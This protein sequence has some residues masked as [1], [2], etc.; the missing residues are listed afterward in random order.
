MQQL[1]VEHDGILYGHTT[2]QRLYKSLNYHRSLSGRPKTLWSPD[3]QRLAEAQFFD[4]SDTAQWCSQSGDFWWVANDAGLS[5]GQGGERLAFFP[6]CQNQQGP[7]HGYP[8]SP[9]SDTNYEV[10]GEIIK[11]W[12]DR[13]TI[14]RIW[15]RRMRR[16]RI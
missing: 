14:N 3:V 13:G 11:E 1:K 9:N 2:N 16:G 8:V 4:I 15:A 6:R 7:W 5:I 12:E 10:P